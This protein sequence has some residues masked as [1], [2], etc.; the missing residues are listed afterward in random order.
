MRPEHAVGLFGGTFDPVHI[1]HLRLA[2]EVIERF[3]L[4]EL[5]LIP[6]AVA[7]LRGATVASGA[8]RLA[9]LSQACHGLDRLRIDDRELRRGGV[10]YTI[11]TL[12]A[13][14]AEHGAGC[15]LF[16]LGMDALLG[17]PQWRDWRAIPELVNLLV[18]T[19]PNTPPPAATG[20]LAELLRVAATDD[21]A[22]L[23]AS[24]HGRIMQC[25]IP[26]FPVSSTDIRERLG[27]GRCIDFLVPDGV[28]DF[29]LQRRLYQP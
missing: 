25:E 21:P 5:R 24:D 20:D 2:L 10:S 3:A 27:Q 19:R 29:I 17:L 23:L 11:D 7:P 1:G 14:R 9:M 16:V 4:A 26:R 15:L 28:R 8:E 12:R 6:N 18:V 13:I 22:T